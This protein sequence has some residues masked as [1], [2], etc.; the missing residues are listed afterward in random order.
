MDHLKLKCFLL[1]SS[2]YFLLL[3]LFFPSPAT[4]DL[5]SDKQALLAFANSV[6]HGPKLNWKSNTPVCSSWVGVTC[7]ADQTHVVTLRLPGVGLSGA[8]PPNTLGKL[9]H[10]QVLSLRSNRLTGNL[11]A[12]VTSLPALQ[13]L[14]LQHNALSGELPTSLSPG[15]CALDLSYNSFSGEIPAAIQNLSQLT[16]LNLQNSLSGFIPD[17]KLP[18]L[19]YLN[20]SYNDL[21]GPIPFSLQ[22][23]PNDSFIGNFQLCGPPLPECSVVLPSP[24]PSAPPL[25]PRPMFPRDNSK[26]KAKKLGTRMIIVIAVGVLTLLLLFSIILV[27]CI[28]KKKKVGEGSEV[29]NSKGFVVVRSDKPKEDF[30]SGVQMAEKNKLVF[31]D[32]CSYNFDLEDLLRSSAEVLGKGSYGTAYK[33]GLEDGMMVVVKRLKEVV[34]GKKEFEQQMEIIGRAGQHQNLL[35]IRAYYYSKDEKLLVYDY[36]P[37][38]SFSA[39]LHGSRQGTGRTPLDWGSRIKIL[40][41]AAKGILHIHLEGGGKLA[42]G[43]IKSSNILLAQDL[44]AF[45]CDFGLAPLMNPPSSASSRVV[46]GYRAPEFI[47]TRKATFKTDVYSFGVLL[48]EALT[49]KSPV[50]APGYD[51]VVDLLRWVHSVVRE[52]WTAEVFDMELI[53]YH[54]IEEEMLQMLQIGMACVSRAP[55]Q[56]PT[57]EEVV[58]MIQEVRRSESESRQSSENKGS[59]AENV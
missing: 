2:Q 15:L 31:F 34:A 43:N 23:L 36:V 54:N 4:S 28:S 11:L 35:P 7:T 59:E 44:S 42:H 18:K 53:G 10:L 6:R 57:M 38:G 49:G 21:N 16:V 33:A 50:Q 46:V 8:I 9:D 56:R 51:D 32:G 12:E 29:S 13:H 19:R 58:R 27:L 20:F 17:L 14:H 30:S 24:S 1:A 39:R 48:L 37:A 25:S 52:E 5:N 41:G 26:S 40:L 45:V 55:E 3:L 22:K 47:E